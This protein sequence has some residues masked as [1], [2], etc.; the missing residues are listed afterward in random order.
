MAYDHIPSLIGL[1]ILCEL[2]PPS[3]IPD[4]KLPPLTGDSVSDPSPLLEEFECVCASAGG[5]V[6]SQRVQ[7]LTQL[8]WRV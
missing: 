5:Q 1:P 4:E 2:P 6:A 7:L 8:L 3:K